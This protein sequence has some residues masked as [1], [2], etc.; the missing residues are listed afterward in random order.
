MADYGH[1]LMFGAM[2][3]PPAERPQDVV[4]LAE[5]IEEVGLDVVSLSDHPYWP[6]RLDTVALLATIVARTKRV[7]VMPNMMNLPLRPPATLARTAA[8]LDILSG[9]R[10]ELGL[11]TGAQQMWDLVVAEDGPR[12]SAGQ[13]IEALEEA[14]R[15]IR[16]LWTSDTEVSLDGRHY[17]LASVKP[18]PRPVHDLGIW[19]GAYQP[20]MLRLVGT[21]ADGWVPSSP[22]LPPQHLSGANQAIDGATVEAGRAPGN[23]RRGYNIEGRFSSGSAFLDGPPRLWVEQLAGLALTQG[24]SAFFLYRADSPD[25]IRQ[26]AEEVAPA[27]RATVAAER[28]AAAKG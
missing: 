23:V 6:E 10:F 20:R 15:I 19:L 2:L 8:T 4:A 28:R 24:I 22:F 25:V 5:L 13:S 21:I 16:A 12:R 7:T 27:V 26:F 9:G 17:R 3:E 11:A 14:V 1:D 18:G